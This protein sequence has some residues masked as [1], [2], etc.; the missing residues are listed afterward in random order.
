M[1]GAIENRLINA[2]F[3]LDLVKKTLPPGEA[4][5]LLNMAIIAAS[6]GMLRMPW[7]RQSRGDALDTMLPSRA[8]R[9]S[10]GRAFIDNDL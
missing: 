5:T 8:Q 1:E 7:P 4:K 3:Q 6:D 9:Q 10:D 2:I